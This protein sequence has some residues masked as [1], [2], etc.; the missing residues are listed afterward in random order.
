MPSIEA[1]DEQS[2]GDVSRD[3]LGERGRRRAEIG[4]RCAQRG[5]TRPVLRLHDFAGARSLVFRYEVDGA[6][7]VPALA[8]AVGSSVSL[9]EFH[10]V[11]R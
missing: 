2:L 1:V 5:S 6:D 4:G 10:G 9:I 7:P 3:V 8:D 11:P